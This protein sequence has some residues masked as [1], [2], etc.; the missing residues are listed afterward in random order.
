MPP[1]RRRGRPIRP[2]KG[3]GDDDRRGGAEI[4]LR[5]GNHLRTVHPSPI[6][7]DQVILVP[8]MF[9]SDLNA[10]TFW[11]LREELEPVL[12]ATP[13]KRP[14]CWSLDAV[15]GDSVLPA[16]G[17]VAAAGPAEAWE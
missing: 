4:D 1:T 17:F 7:S 12:R 5:T 15:E 9:G 6:R 14:D 8:S 16:P 10:T 13:R 3:G 11:D 2:S